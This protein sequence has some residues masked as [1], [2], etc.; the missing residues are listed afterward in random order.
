MGKKIEKKFQVKQI[1]KRDKQLNKKNLKR[2]YELDT[3]DNDIE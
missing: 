3:E 1:L 2:K